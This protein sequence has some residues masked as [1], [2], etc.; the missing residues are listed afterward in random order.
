MLSNLHIDL[1]ARDDDDDDTRRDDDDGNNSG[2][3][4]STE[5]RNDGESLMPA[6]CCDRKEGK[7]FPARLR[8]AIC[9]THFH[10]LD[11]SPPLTTIIVHYHKYS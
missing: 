9:L 11:H 7:R 2:W 4:S 6:P 5:G 8:S 1:A 3:C 10:L